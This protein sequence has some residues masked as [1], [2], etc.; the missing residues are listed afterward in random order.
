[1]I[2]SI[3]SLNR[4]EQDLEGSNL[5]SDVHIGVMIF[6]NDW[7]W[8]VSYMTLTKKSNRKVNPTN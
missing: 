3:N 6:D 8:N 5:Y 7:G 4:L 2:C 1:M